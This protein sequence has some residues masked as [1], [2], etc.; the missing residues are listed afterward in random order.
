MIRLLYIALFLGILTACS[1]EKTTNKPD[2][3]QKETSQSVKARNKDFKKVVKK[4]EGTKFERRSKL[5]KKQKNSL[6]ST[7][8]ALN[9]WND[10]INHSDVVKIHDCY[11]GEKVRYYL[12]ELDAEK[13]ANSKINWLK[14]HKGYQQKLG[15]VE[16]QYPDE[17]KDIIRCFFEKI[18]IE[19]SKKDTLYAIV[20]FKKSKGDY[21]IVRETD[22]ASEIAIAKRAKPI[23]LPEGEASYL[24]YCWV[25]TR[26]D[27]GLAHSFVPYRIHITTS[28]KGYNLNVSLVSYSG[29]IRSIQDY[30]VKDA[31]FMDGELTFKAAPVWGEWDG[32]EEDLENVQHGDFDHY[33][34][35]LT[36]K[37]MYLMETSGP[38][39]YKTGTRFY[40]TDEFEEN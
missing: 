29:R 20:D 27:K 22:L 8:F 39:A 40:H 28:R 17:D 3:E 34:F 4:A 18:C 19:N 36:D 31:D 32:T 38:F 21:V 15:R 16:V 9:I 35:R 24:N 14:K 13:I 33:K 1:E 37:G 30:A 10:G 25:D 6:D 12:K 7:L 23:D 26:N 5:W 11:S 2:K